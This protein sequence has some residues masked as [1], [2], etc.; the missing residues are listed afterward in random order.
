[1]KSTCLMCF[2]LLAACTSSSTGTGSSGGGGSSA[3]GSSGASDGPT[4]ACLDTADAVA[5]AAQRCGQDYKANYDAFIQTGAG[6]Q[7]SN[8][9]QIRDEPT[10]RNTCLP[11]M[12]K[13]PC[14]DF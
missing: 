5:K 10:L 13:I 2:F 1:M 8:I 9:V 14:P 11:S 6:G 4:Q 7:C 12:I 3:G